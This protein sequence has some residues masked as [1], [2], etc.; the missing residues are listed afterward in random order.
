MLAF[1]RIREH[2]ESCHV[3]K[4]YGKVEIL[5]TVQLPESIQVTHAKVSDNN[6]QDHANNHDMETDNILDDEGPG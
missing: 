1:F 4:G 6:I 2:F 5:R 3:Y